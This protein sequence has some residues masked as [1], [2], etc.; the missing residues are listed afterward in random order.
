[1]YTKYWKITGW[2]LLAFWIICALLGVNHINAGLITSYGADISIPAWLYISL[3]SLD[4]PKRQP[5]VYNIFRRSPGITATILFFASTL[6][7]VSQYFWPKGIFTGRFDYFDILAY[8][9]GVGICYYFDKLLL[10]RS[11]QLTNKIN[12]KVRAV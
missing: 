5:H 6:T 10:G 2:L 8:A 11:K 4:N 1:M 7:E 9:I 3:R 12:Q